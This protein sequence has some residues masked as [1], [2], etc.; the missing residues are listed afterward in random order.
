MG[1]TN[2]EDITDGQDMQAAFAT[3]REQALWEHGHGGYTGRPQPILYVVVAAYE[4][5]RLKRRVAEADPDAFV[6]I[7]SAQ[8][9]LGEGFTPATTE[10]DG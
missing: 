7:S 9:V 10:D 6:A 1:A 3:A 2:F 5:G 8:E 4:V